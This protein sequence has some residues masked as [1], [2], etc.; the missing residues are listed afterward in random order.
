MLVAPFV[1]PKS[2]HIFFSFQTRPSKKFGKVIFWETVVASAIIGFY[3]ESLWG[4]VISFLG[5]LIAWFLPFIGTAMM[6]GIS[7]TYSWLAFQILDGFHVHGAICFLVAAMVFLT[8][9]GSHVM[10]AGGE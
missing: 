7:G 5:I 6:I 3:T 8:S 4:G 10:T 2:Y 1:F 9:F